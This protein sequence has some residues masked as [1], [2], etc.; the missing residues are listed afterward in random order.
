[1]RNQVV[2]VETTTLK[3]REHAGEVAQSLT[4][5]NGLGFELV[6]ATTAIRGPVTETY[7]FFKKD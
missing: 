1:M 7:L 3:G 5:F 4:T 2:I 6:T